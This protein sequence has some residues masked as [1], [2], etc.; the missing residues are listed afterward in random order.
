MGSGAFVREQ[1]SREFLR[2]RGRRAR[3]GVAV[4]L[5]ERPLKLSQEI[6]AA[7]QL[8]QADATIAILKYSGEA[9]GGERSKVRASS[10]L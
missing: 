4:H 6:R 7:A 2:V 3:Q 8:P 5:K 1:V 10:A 9:S